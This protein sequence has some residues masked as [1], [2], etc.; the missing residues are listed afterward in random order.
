MLNLFII[1]HAIAEDRVVFSSQEGCDDLRALTQKGIEK[2]HRN[3]V[4]IQKIINHFD[5]L[6]TSPLKRAKQTAEIVKLTIPTDKVIVT[7]NLRP[8]A[9][10]KELFRDLESFKS[11]K[12][13]ALVGHEPNLSSLVS[14]F[15]TG[16]ESFGFHIKK[17]SLCWIQSS[18]ELAKGKALLRCLLTPSMLR[19]IGRN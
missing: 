10:P 8:N 1:R 5:I 6:L 17:G 11:A 3:T 15:L 19:E 7:E 14:Y 4:G 12:N 2:M 18:F 13:I 16:K 9:S